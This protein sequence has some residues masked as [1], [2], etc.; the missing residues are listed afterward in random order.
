MER[1]QQKAINTKEKNPAEREK[2]P[3]TPFQCTYN[4][5]YSRSTDVSVASSRACHDK[6]SIIR[7]SSVQKEKKQQQQQLHSIPI[8]HQ[9]TFRQERKESNGN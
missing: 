1:E 7:S 6:I 9:I 8:P 3:Y 4:I 5:Q 2:S